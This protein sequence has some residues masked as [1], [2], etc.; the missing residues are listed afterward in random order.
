[1]ALFFI[2][3]DKQYISLA[4]TFI[5]PYE[6]TCVFLSSYLRR[7]SKHVYLISKKDNPQ[8]TGDLHGVIYIESSVFH[9]IPHLDEINFLEFQ[10][11]LSPLFQEIKIKCISGEA[12]GTDYIINLL[13]DKF[14]EPYQTNHYNL[15]TATTVQNPPEDLCN[16]DQIIR[17]T[18]NDMEELLP[19][20]KKYMNEEV[21]PFGKKASDAEVAMGLRQILKNQ[22][23]LALYSDD[24]IVAK[25]NTNAIGVNW[26]QLGGIYTHPLYRRNGYAW[27]LI[28]AILRRT[29]KAG[30]KAAL[31]VKDI[32]V[33]AMEL[34]KKLG[35]TNSG[36]YTIGYY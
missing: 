34:Y 19:I 4:K 32:N 30:K 10:R 9:C 12:K 13:K 18:E 31:F 1:M 20:Q 27:Q 24:E 16:D 35:F 25:A 36:L 21:A 7:G 2:P 33:P 22:L 29:S 8:K 14:G 15:M 28:S 26:I 3:V 5:E 17:C 11:G 23:C 6:E